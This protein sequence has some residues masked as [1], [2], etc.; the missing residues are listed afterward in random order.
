MEKNECIRYAI[1][2]F[3]IPRDLLPE[4]LDDLVADMDEAEVEKSVLLGQDVRSSS[5]PQFKNYSLPNEE[6]KKI[7]DSHPDRFL[8][9]GS[10]DP[11]KDDALSKLR[12]MALDY[13]FKGL[14][15][16]G[17]ASEVYPNDHVLY[18]IYEKC[19]E[20]GLVVLHHTG[21]TGLGYCKIKYG[22]PLDLDDVAQDFPELKIISAHFGWPWIEECFAV[23]TRNKN[24]YIDV[25]GW[26]PRYFPSLL[27]TYMNGLLKEKILFG[28]DYPMIRTTT[29]MKDFEKYTEPHLNSGVAEKILHESAKKLLML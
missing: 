16:H 7:V 29:W 28:T 12:Q 10:V 8:A 26:L 5:V 25:S 14:K 20:Y 21:T 27:I 1:D 19:V 6:L 4:S 18:P 17:D 11:R 13:D 15:I 22:R 3:K 23:A 9:F 24:V 2:F